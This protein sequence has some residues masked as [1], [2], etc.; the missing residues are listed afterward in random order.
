MVNRLWQYHFGEALARSPSD[1]GLMGDPP[2]HPELLDWLAV[3][4]PELHWSMKSLTRLM[5][6]STTYQQAS[7]AETEEAQAALAKSLAADP[8]NHYLARMSRRRLDGESIRDA[9]LVSA[10]RLGPRKGAP[11]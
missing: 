2:S 7:R 6:T 5:V 10:E 9:M 1:F 3:E 11:A 8:E 4:F